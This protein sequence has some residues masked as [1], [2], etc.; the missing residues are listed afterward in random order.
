MET[1]QE[2][3][4]HH[5]TAML[6]ALQKAFDL[7]DSDND[8]YITAEEMMKATSHL[9]KKEAAVAVAWADENGD[10]KLDFVEFKNLFVKNV[11]LE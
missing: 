1:L 2:E 4:T 8:G 11:I 7:Y 10:R 3:I 5:V 6:A 9:S